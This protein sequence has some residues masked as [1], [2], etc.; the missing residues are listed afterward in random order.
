M[1]DHGIRGRGCDEG[2]RAGPDRRVGDGLEVAQGRGVAEDDPPQTRTVEATLDREHLG[3]ETVG[4]GGQRG[5]AGF[6]DLARHGIRVDDH[7]SE[8]RELG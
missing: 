1:H 7:G 8:R 6:D 3:A 5:G 2:G 4:D